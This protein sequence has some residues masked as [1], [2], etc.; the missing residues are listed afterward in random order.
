[1]Q[2]LHVELMHHAKVNG[3]CELKAWI[4][5]PVCPVHEMG[6]LPKVGQHAVLAHRL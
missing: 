1:M 2:T 5:A 6:G 4:Q 3:M